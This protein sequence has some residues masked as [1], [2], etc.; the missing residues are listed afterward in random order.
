MKLGQALALIQ[1]R[2]G[3]SRKRKIFLVC[4]FQPL[5]LSTFLQGHFAQRF[6]DET[7]E[8]QMGLYGDFERT[9]LKAAESEAESA[10][11]VIEWSDL[12]PRLGCRASGG[13][14][15]SAE[16]DIIL[17]C[18]NRF[19]AF[20]PRLEDLASKMSVALA[21][22]TLP[23]P[24][25]GH[26][27]GW[28]MSLP[29]AELERQIG[30]FAVAAARLQ[31]VRVVHSARLAKLSPEEDRLDATMEVRAGFPYTLG[32]ASALAL[33]FIHLLYPASPM[34]GLISDLDETLWSGIVG[35]VGASHVT[36]SLPEHSQVHGLYQQQLKQLSEMGIL[37][38]IATKNDAAVV[39]DALGRQ[40]LYIS[41]DAFFP[42][43]ANW[44]PK[45]AGVA[46]I[47]RTWNIGAESV[48]YVDDAPMELEEVHTAFPSM[49]CL[50]FPTNSPTKAL[51]LLEQLRDL[52]GR[53][54]LSQDDTL[55]QS[56]IRA[57][58]R[59]REVASQTSPDEF[60]RGLQAKLTFQTQKDASNT[61]LL[62]LINKTNQFNLNG[63]RI[64]E[65]E[66]LRFLSDASTFGVG[67]RYEDKFGPMG[68][69]SVIAGRQTG[70]Q[71]DVQTWVLSCR[72]FSR[73]IELHILDYLF[74]SRAVEKI[75]L[76]FK[77]TER[78]HPLQEFLIS[79]NLPADS[80]GECCIMREEFLRFGYDLPHK[81]ITA[82]EKNVEDTGHDRVV[83]LR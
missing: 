46:E 81:I 58:A 56:S 78:N 65:G 13:W 70:R 20:L 39:E 38:A 5:H 53:S 74:R 37:L 33:Q 82:E 59:F 80:D 77:P 31:N 48:V 11:V 28:Q 26:T 49:R 54:T 71:L 76:A 79:L 12:D 69:I 3:T 4:G 30:E 25:F 40:D 47:L 21:L 1:Q 41:R 8:I 57:N 73:N 34:K 22:S 63:V 29:E 83:K 66:W 18:R 52:F 2:Q 44:K 68:V 6:H 36:W 75:T 17:N 62:E 19:A 55:R 23:I 45:S 24:L 27:S 7:V 9:L 14:G 43:I 32:H 51:H 35:E 72:A 64:S 10:V 42:V 15:P 16:Q 50:Q 61:R 67:V 60:I